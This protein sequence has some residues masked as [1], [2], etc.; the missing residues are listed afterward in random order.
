MAYALIRE[1]V[2][3]RSGERF[4]DHH[5]VPVDNIDNFSREKYTPR[6]KYHFDVDET[7]LCGVIQGF[8]DD[9]AKLKEAT[10]KRLSMPTLKKCQTNLACPKTSTKRTAQQGLQAADKAKE[11]KKKP[12]IVKNEVLQDPHGFDLSKVKQEFV[13]ARSKKVSKTPA[14]PVGDGGGGKKIYNSRPTTFLSSTQHVK[15]QVPTDGLTQTKEVSRNGGTSSWS[16]AAAGQL[17]VDLLK[18]SKTS[19]LQ[20]PVNSGT[21]KSTQSL[22]DTNKDNAPSSL[23]PLTPPI[24]KMGNGS[25]ESDVPN[26]VE[27][28][29]QVSRLKKLVQEQSLTIAKQ[30]KT[31]EDLRRVVQDKQDLLADATRTCVD[32]QKKTLNNFD[33]LFKLVSDLKQA[34]PNTASPDGSYKSIGFINTKDFTVHVGRD[35]YIPSNKWRYACSMVKPQCFVNELARALI[36]ESV[37]KK[38]TVTGGGSHRDGS[39]NIKTW[40]PV[41]PLKI[42]A[43]RDA[44]GFFLEA[45]KFSKMKAETKAEHVL[46][47]QTYIGSLIAELKKNKTKTAGKSTG[48][49][50]A[51]LKK[52]AQADKIN[53]AGHEIGGN[54]NHELISIQDETDQNGK[55]NQQGVGSGNISESEK[56]DEVLEILNEQELSHHERGDDREVFEKEETDEYLSEKL[57]KE[58]EADDSRKYEQ[59]ESLIEEDHEETNEQNQGCE[60]DYHANWDGD[61]RLSVSSTDE[62]IYL[63]RSK[64]SQESEDDRTP[65]P[66]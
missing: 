45:N 37:L 65:V 46:S 54:E 17:S 61:D 3:D 58:L 40:E 4:G 41:D 24:P 44:L 50:K 30:Q 7:T 6:T 38:S 51:S 21:G 59:D 5:I 15:D 62:T 55:Q 56:D 31:I 52:K 25:G 28:D 60:S 32:L 66:R 9:P 33:E 20:K 8:N 63:S 43:I 23:V 48:T 29:D 42:E 14:T 49:P 22:R 27:S 35:F 64:N 12:R 26:A 2:K 36:G 57:C 34:N 16:D 19:T 11:A 10:K 13:K 18:I 1:I 47:V 53:G 39:G